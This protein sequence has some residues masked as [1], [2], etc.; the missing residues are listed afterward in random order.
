MNTQKFTKPDW[1]TY[2]LAQA[3]LVAMRSPDPRTK[4]GAVIVSNKNRI[5]SVGYNGGIAGANQNISIWHSDNKYGVVIH[6]QTN[7]ILNLNC[8]LS[9]T[10]GA[11]IYITGQP[12]NNCLN[13]IIQ[14][15][16]KNIKYAH[17]KSKMIDEKEQQV[18]TL[19][20]SY[21]PSD[22][23]IMDY[24]Y[25]IQNVRKLL[26]ETIRYIDYKNQ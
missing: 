24:S 23:T 16:I 11:T 3:F 19:I 15:G 10:Q 12:C 5:L 25:S 18:K 14:S 20:K 17:V 26:N 22:V 2:F 8:S 9:D 6:A 1:D 13:N 4:H 7:A 21:M